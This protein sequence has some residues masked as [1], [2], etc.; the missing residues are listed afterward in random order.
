MKNKQ[1]ALI[2]PPD[3][4]VI[5]EKRANF[6]YKWYNYIGGKVILT[7]KALYFKSHKLNLKEDTTRIVLENI[8][9]LRK[10]NSLK[11][12]PNRMIVGDRDGN[13]YTFVVT[14]RNE[15]Y[16]AVEEQLK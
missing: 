8:H 2:L 10:G 15:F 1:S 3:E 12:I 4:K 7:N 9:V 14:N 11:V 13:E 16:N 5:L 6:K